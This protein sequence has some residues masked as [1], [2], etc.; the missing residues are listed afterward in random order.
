MIKPTKQNEFKY[1]QDF[2]AKLENG[3]PTGP[4][5]L[6]N[7]MSHYDG[8]NKQ[9]QSEILTLLAWFPASP[10]HSIAEVLYNVPIKAFYKEYFNNA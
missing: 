10:C 6:E 4:K 9:K 2:V 5:E 7:I 8:A 1:Y 3:E